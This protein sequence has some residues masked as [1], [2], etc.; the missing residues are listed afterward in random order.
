M[1][2]LLNP[3]GYISWT[4]LDMWTRSR[5]R[6]MDNYMPA[7]NARELTNSGLRFGKTASDALEGG[8]TTDAA[9]EAL[10]ALLPHYSKR[11][12]EIRA[13]LK[14]PKG[15]VDLLGKLDTF[16]PSPPRFREYKTGRVP[17]T[18]AKANRHRQ[19]KHYAALIYLKYGKVPTETHLDW[20]ETVEEQN[21]EGN[22]E[23]RLTGR[24]ETFPVKPTLQ[25]I[26]EYLALASKVA[27]EIDEAYRAELKKLA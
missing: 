24:I 14:T 27:Q 25:D 16:D 23:V 8:E 7:G 22:M 2:K 5:Q 13:A 9:M 15:S 4:Q 1:A 10:V 17:W 26:L 20:A 19:I 3:R 11:E 21:D 18:Q 6:Y 12:H